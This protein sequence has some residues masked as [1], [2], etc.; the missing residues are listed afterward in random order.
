M[1]KK[2]LKLFDKTAIEVWIKQKADA[3]MEAKNLN[4]LCD[5]KAIE[6][7]QDVFSRIKKEVTH[8]KLDDADT[9]LLTDYLDDNWDHINKPNVFDLQKVIEQFNL[10][11][12]EKDA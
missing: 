4:I 3:V 8:Y 1:A 6:E 5:S 7:Y 9:K 10:D 12:E 11:K 2:Q